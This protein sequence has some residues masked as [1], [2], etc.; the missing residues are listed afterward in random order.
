MILCLC[1]RISDRD[2]AREAARGCP[3]FDALQDETRLGTACGAC[4]DFAREAFETRRMAVIGKGGGCR[5]MQ[6]V[7]SLEQTGA[8]APN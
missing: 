1:H 8:M 2:L 6:P 5:S 4:V 3:S 7:T